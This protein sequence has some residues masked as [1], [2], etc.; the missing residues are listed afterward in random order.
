MVNGNLMVEYS[1]PMALYSGNYAKNHMTGIISLPSFPVPVFMQLA[2]RDNTSGNMEYNISVPFPI[3][4][5]ALT[6]YYPSDNM[7]TSSWKMVP[8]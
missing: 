1:F 6:L 7:D 8:A 2:G 4:N 3:Y 5:P